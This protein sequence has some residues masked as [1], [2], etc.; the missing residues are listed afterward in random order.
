MELRRVR[1]GRLGHG[2]KAG[3]VG[4]RGLE[5][6]LGSLGEVAA[7]SAAAVVATAAAMVVAAG[8]GH[9]LVVLVNAGVALSEGARRQGERKGC[10]QECKN[11]D[12]SVIRPHR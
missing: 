2:R 7:A 6:G 4:P 1:R 10:D 3:A 11:W 9:V 8:A 5:R 12:V